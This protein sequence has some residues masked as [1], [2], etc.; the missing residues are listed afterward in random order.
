M[1]AME[2]EARKHRW[3]AHETDERGTF[4]ERRYTATHTPTLALTLSRAHT[5]SL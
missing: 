2:T 1:D 3:N 5:L 4:G